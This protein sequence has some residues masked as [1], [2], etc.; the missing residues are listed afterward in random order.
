LST[1]LVFGATGPVGRVL[2]PQLLAAGARVL[3]VS[4][5]PPPRD[6]AGPE[7]IEGDLFAELAPP[8]AGVDLIVSLGPLDA[9]AAW[10]E[11][12]APAGVRRVVALSSMSA[13]S[14]QASP[15]PS[16]RDLALRLRAAE[17]RL[18]QAA[19]R[20][21][22]GWTVLRPTLIYGDGSDRSLAP[23]ARFMRRWRIL[24]VPLG[25]T[26]LRQPVHAADLASA[27]LATLERSASIGRIYAVGGGE[28]LRFDALLE[29]LRAAVPGYV[30]RLPLPMF[31]LRLALRLHGGPIGAAAL[32]RLR[33]P[34]IADNEAAARDLD[35]CPR[36]FI[37]ADVLPC[38]A[39]DPTR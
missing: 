25:A 10:F 33:E 32:R 3:A 23:I 19:T 30:L 27:I 20:R 9:F 24:P 29:R 4:R 16:E 39:Q 22:A 38:G 7:W 36:P 13:H 17:M 15:D 18:A 1:F 21:G 34:L 26:G 11:R 8:A 2:V 28:R 12:H 14:K 31:L 5:A 35:Y 37:A 6:A